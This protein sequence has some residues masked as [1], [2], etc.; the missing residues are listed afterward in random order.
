MVGPSGEREIDAD[1]FF[2][3][4]DRNIHGENVLAANELVTHVLLPA[5]ARRRRA[6]LRGAL[7]AVARLAAGDGVRRPRDGRHAPSSVRA[8]SWAPSRRSP[9]GRQTAEAGARWQ[10]DQRGSGPAAADAAVK[11]AKPMTENGYKVQIAR[12]AVKRAILKA[13]GL[14][15]PAFTA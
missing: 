15:V 11:D 2:L 12:T 5:P 4:P 1:E 9:G 3:M 10:G 6:H 13:A 7:Q 14:S 8:S